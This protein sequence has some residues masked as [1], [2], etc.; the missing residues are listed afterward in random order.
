MSD[1]EKH[2]EL[3]TTRDGSV[4]LNSLEVDE[5]CHSLE[6][7]FEETKYNFV[8]GC[9]LHDWRRFGNSL[10]ILEMGFGTGLGPIV[11]ADFFSHLDSAPQK[12]EFVSLE[13]DPLLLEWAQKNQ[14]GLGDLQKESE[15]K[16]VLKNTKSNVSFHLE[17][18]IGDGIDN[19]QKY[20]AS[21]QLQPFHCIYQ[22]PFSPKK[23]PRFWSEEWFQLLGCCSHLGAILSTYSASSSVRANLRQSGWDVHDRSGFAKK[24]SCTWA[25]W[26]TP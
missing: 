6:G 7:A 8:E 1:F 18:W 23:N 13:K 5:H 20:L 26:R 22:D 15:D 19:L 14:P 21:S 25:T 16:W 24:R 10:R 4:T 3:V 17:V 11:T 2:Y 12:V 9:R